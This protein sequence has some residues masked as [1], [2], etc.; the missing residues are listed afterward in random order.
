[1]KKYLLIIV[2]ILMNCGCTNINN[3]SYEN[4]INLNLKKTIP[5]TNEYRSGYLYYLPKGLRLIKN[6]GSNEILAKDNN[7]YY[8]YFLNSYI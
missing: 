4:L 8:L 6:E 2:I 1:M 7:Y 3:N 5:T